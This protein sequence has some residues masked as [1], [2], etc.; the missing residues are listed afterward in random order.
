MLQEEAEENG[1][2]SVRAE[3]KIRRKIYNLFETKEEVGK[4]IVMQQILLLSKWGKIRAEKPKMS[5][6][7]TIYQQQ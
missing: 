6:L 4:R 7:E 2:L 5:F 3:K 1:R